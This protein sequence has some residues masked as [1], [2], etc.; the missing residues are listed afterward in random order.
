MAWTCPHCGKTFAKDKQSHICVKVDPLSIFEGK[1][2]QLPSLYKQVL[3]TLEEFCEFQIT[4]STKSITLYGKAHR[5][6]MVMK[7]KK[8]W[9]DLWFS[10]NREVDEFPVYKIM[11]HSKTRFAHF[12]R[13]EDHDDLQPIIFDWIAEAYVLSNP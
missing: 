5:S 13:L 4:T 1:A 7:P 6:F 10:L 9:I 12:V 8:K 2:P 3:E 11:Q